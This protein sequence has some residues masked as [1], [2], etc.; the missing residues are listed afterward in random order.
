MRRL[1]KIIHI[2]NQN[3]LILKGPSAQISA[4]RIGQPVIDK[5]LNKIGRIFDIFGPISQPYIS[6]RPNPEISDPRKYIGEVLYCSDEKKTSNR[7]RSRR[8]GGS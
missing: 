7:S 6:I 1:E 8:R 4:L 3:H 5:D 2:S